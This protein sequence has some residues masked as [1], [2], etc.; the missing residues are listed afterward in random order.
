[1]QT[2]LKDQEAQIES[3]KQENE[4]LIIENQSFA[5]NIS[6]LNSKLSKFREICNFVASNGKISQ[7]KIDHSNYCNINNDDKNDS[8]T[9]ISKNSQTQSSPNLLRAN[10]S[11]L[12]R[13]FET[14]P[15]QNELSKLYHKGGNAIFTFCFNIFLQVDDSANKF[16]FLSPVII[17]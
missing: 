4:T 2:I 12:P 11:F 3:L 10:S 9:Q 15:L 6:E 8:E 13:N 16:E 14:N 5:I 1:M 17:F 7:K